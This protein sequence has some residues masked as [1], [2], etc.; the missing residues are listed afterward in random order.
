M[1]VTRPVAAQFEAYNA[2]DIDA[3]MA[4]FADDFRGYRM[5]AEMPS[6]QGKPALRDFYIDIRY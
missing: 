4:C 2:H 3:F 1:S 5:P 6:T